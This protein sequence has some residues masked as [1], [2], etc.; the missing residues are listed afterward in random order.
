[1]SFLLFSFFLQILNEVITYE[2]R[3]LENVLSTVCDRGSD[4]STNFKPVRRRRKGRLF[5]RTWVAT[6]QLFKRFQKWI[7]ELKSADWSAR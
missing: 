3:R 6:K 2:L 4:S 5:R 7:L 1:M